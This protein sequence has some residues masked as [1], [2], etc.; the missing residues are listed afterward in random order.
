MLRSQRP[1][2]GRVDLARLPSQ[3]VE[4]PRGGRSLDKIFAAPFYARG[5]MR[6]STVE[7]VAERMMW[8]RVHKRVMPRVQEHQAVEVAV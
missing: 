3:R 4:Q 6:L 1:S 5:V 2:V 7:R 8:L